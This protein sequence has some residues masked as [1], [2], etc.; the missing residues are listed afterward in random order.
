MRLT[1]LFTDGKGTLE[2]VWFKGIKFIL[3][4]YSTGKEYVV[5]G[6]PTAFNGRYSLVHP[7]IDLVSQLPPAETMGLQP[8][9]N[10]T[11]KMKSGFLNSKTIQKII[12]PLINGLK[13]GI[14]D[15][16]PASVLKQFALMNLTDSLINVHFPKNANALNK[17]RQRLKF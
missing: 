13:S 10:T 9:Y 7:E 2:L 14:P 4:K 5:F 11:E 3:D 15:S 1:A 17:A 12:F 8:F 6:K 16:L